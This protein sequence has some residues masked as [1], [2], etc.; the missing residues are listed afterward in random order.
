[1]FNLKNPKFKYVI[2]FVT[3]LLMFYY[4]HLVYSYL[5]GVSQASKERAAKNSIVGLTYQE[6]EQIA[7]ATCIKGAE[8][9]TEGIYNVG[10]KTWWFDANLNATK[11]GCNPACVVS[12]ETKTAEINW[13]C[14][15]LIVPVDISEDI[16]SLFTLKYPE[17]RGSITIRID[18]QTSDHI[19]GGVTFVDD[20]AGGI[21][22]ATKIDGVWQ[23]VFDGNGA[24]PCSSNKYGFPS[25]MLVDC[26]Q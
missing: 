2:L 20:Q 13:R 16:K 15:G 23:L 9:L 19:R 12:E 14:T 21:F 22:L 26:A 17:Y 6:A 4:I 24:I 1:M 18:Q 5:W 7:E 10:T 8:S 11:E 3:A 25:E